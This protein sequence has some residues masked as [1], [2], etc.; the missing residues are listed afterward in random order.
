MRRSCWQLTLFAVA[1]FMAASSYAQSGR[2]KPEPTPTPTS[3]S[4][5]VVT[6]SPTEPRSTA[7]PTPS[8]V[9]SPR[10]GGDDVIR[11]DSTLVPIPV[12]VGD[13]RGR[14]IPGLR[15]NDFS[16]AIDGKPAEIGEVSFSGAP[17][18][19]A[20]LF[21][22]SSSALAAR[23]L[24]IAAATRF[25]KRVLRPE[26]D[27]GALFS[28][29]DTTRLEQPLTSNVGSLIRAIE[30]FPPPRGATALLDGIIK[31]ADYLSSAAGRRVIVIVSDG[32]D[33]YSEL[34]TTLEI[35][36][37]SLQ[38][39]D[40]LVYVV[41]TKEFENYKM[42]GRRG[43]NANIR[44]LTAAR[45]MEE[46]TRQTGGAVYSPIDEREIEDAFDRIS[47]ELAQQ[48][49]LSYYP[50]EN[51]GGSGEFREIEVKIIGRSDATVRSRRGYYVRRKP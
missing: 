30:A 39:N 24:E 4:R 45:R 15:A 9:P 38:I 51:G 5:P 28:V 25:F 43:G 49:V 12:F 18:R 26:R 11:V 42:T 7:T 29:A 10:E 3:G 46:I 44:A 8:P 13:A 14:V 16:L 47:A 20:M 22:N 48:Y 34:K 41:N 32:E 37:R 33:T 40:C 19:L 31:A 17:L 27:M 2:Q 6:Y 36:I 1:S 50:D 23:D 21:D 35:V